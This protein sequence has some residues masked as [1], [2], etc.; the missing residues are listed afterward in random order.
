MKRKLAHIGSS[1]NVSS[2]VSLDAKSLEA[3]LL[4]T[5]ETK[6]KQHKLGGVELHDA[7]DRS[8]MRNI[9]KD[10]LSL[11]QQPPPSSTDHSA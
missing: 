8:D 11:I 4:R 5:E 7:S 9:N 1:L 10:S 2:G 3:L 6:R